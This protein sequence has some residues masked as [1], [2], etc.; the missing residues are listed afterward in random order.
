MNRR[1]VIAASV[2]ALLITGGAYAIGS[3]YQ[4][5]SGQP[6]IE[7]PPNSTNINETDTEQVITDPEPPEPP[8]P[9]ENTSEGG[10][11]SVPV[12]NGTET[13]SSDNTTEEDDDNYDS[14]S[15]GYGDEEEP[16]ATENSS[17]GVVAQ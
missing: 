15:W 1:G 14:W 6:S 7:G 5:G 10:N 9:P 4:N 13:N 2:A 17:I 11:Q 16:T 12:P 3:S 8:E